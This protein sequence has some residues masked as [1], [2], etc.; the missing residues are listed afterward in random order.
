MTMLEA[1]EKSIAHWERMR[2]YTRQRNDYM[3]P[4]DGMRYDIG[5]YPGAEYCDLCLKYTDGWGI[6]DCYKCPIVLSG[7]E[8]CKKETSAY[9]KT[10]HPVATPFMAFQDFA[11]NV[12]KYMLPCLRKALQWCKDNEAA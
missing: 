9:F 12:D 6:I 11:D 1:C 7:Q 10:T 8:S 2:D 5:E 4:I 3:Y